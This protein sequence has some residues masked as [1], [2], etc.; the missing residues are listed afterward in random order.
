MLLTLTPGSVVLG[1][2][3]EEKLLFIHAMDVP[4]SQKT[5]VKATRTFEKAIMEVTRNV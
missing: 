4:S 1:V 2:V 3:P 5:V